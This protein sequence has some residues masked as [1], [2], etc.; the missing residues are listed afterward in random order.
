MKRETETPAHICSLCFIL[1]Y[2]TDIL[3]FA[4]CRIDSIVRPWMWL[5]RLMWMLNDRILF[6]LLLMRLQINLYTPKYVKLS[7]QW[8]KRSQYP[9]EGDKQ[10]PIDRL[11]L[12]YRVPWI[13][14]QN[15]P[16]AKYISW[17]PRI[18]IS[19]FLC[20]PSALRHI[21][22]SCSRLPQAHEAY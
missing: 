22:S 3:L 10:P 2:Y 11:L 5:T 12:A 14:F 8:R 16:W 1:Y 13:G 15:R 20:P 9:L 21:T 6:M 4:I 19:S 7:L 18:Y 17:W